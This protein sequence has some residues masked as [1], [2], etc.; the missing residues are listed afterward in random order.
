MPDLYRYGTTE[1]VY[2]KVTLS[3]AGVAGLTFQAADIKLSIDNGAAINIG[4]E[5]TEAA[6]G[7]GAYLWTPSVA[8]RTQGKQLVINIKDDV[9]SAFDENMIILQTGGDSS[10]YFNAT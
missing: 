3:N 4:T 8:S 5:C 2:F 9:G 10:A 1:P 6:L 7:L